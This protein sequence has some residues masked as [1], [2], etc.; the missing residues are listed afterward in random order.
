MISPQHII[1]TYIYENIFT[2]FINT[3][4]TIA[5]ALAEQKQLTYEK[6]K[7]TESK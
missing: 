1:T 3:V 4:N 2:V 5:K 6:E 7:R